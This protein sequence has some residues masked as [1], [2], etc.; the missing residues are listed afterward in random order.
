MQFVA[1]SLQSPPSHAPSRSPFQFSSISS[2]LCGSS[3]PPLLERRCHTVAERN[4]GGATKGVAVQVRGR[5]CHPVARLVRQQ[6]ARRREGAAPARVATLGSASATVLTEY[7][8]PAAH[9]HDHLV[10]KRLKLQEGLEVGVARH[11]CSTRPEAQLGVHVAGRNV[12]ADQ[13][14]DAVSLPSTTI[15]EQEGAAGTPRLSVQHTTMIT[16]PAVSSGR[17]AAL[18]C[19]AAGWARQT[20]RADASHPACHKVRSTTTTAPRGPQPRRPGGHLCT[21]GAVR[22]AARAPLNRC[23]PVLHI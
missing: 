20:A 15:C 23:L 22:G 10:L 13:L 19:H 5:H 14:F 8:H 12:S 9:S 21:R 4:L 11:A 18:Q 2:T 7:K 3:G 6:P 1:S 17:P 16:L